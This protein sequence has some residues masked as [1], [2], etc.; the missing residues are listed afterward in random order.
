MASLFQ[1]LHNI[2]GFLLANG[3]ELFAVRKPQVRAHII[4]TISQV[5]LQVLVSK[6]FL[7]VV[8]DGIRE[9]GVERRN[10]LEARFRRRHEANVERLV[11]ILKP[12]SAEVRKR[13][14]AEG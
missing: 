3:L 12:C 4:G 10:G 14:L 7:V 2:G 1:S 6:Y 5:D 8:K 11:G 9:L 13:G